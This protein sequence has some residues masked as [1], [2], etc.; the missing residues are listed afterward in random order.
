MEKERGSSGMAR[1]G[2]LSELME[3]VQKMGTST[4]E[5]SLSQSGG[6]A[7]PASSGSDLSKTPAIH[8]VSHKNDSYD[9]EYHTQS[10]EGVYDFRTMLR[11][12]GNPQH[13]IA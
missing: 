1:E 4:G 13:S 11:L 5:T 8:S 2:R 6:T 12:F 7:A 3:S 9:G 10:V